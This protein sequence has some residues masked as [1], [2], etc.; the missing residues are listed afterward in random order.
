MELSISTERIVQYGYS[1]MAEVVTDAPPPGLDPLP[2][3]DSGNHALSEAMQTGASAQNAVASTSGN[4]N[5]SRMAAPPGLG[6]D[7]LGENSEKNNDFGG[8]NI[9]NSKTSSGETGK[10][11][12]NSALTCYAK[13]LLGE[14]IISANN[15]DNGHNTKTNFRT[16]K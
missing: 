8:D 12:R 2:A 6:D 4:I 1:R 15:L 11:R 10:E 3:T 7:N 9:D 16:A 13:N 5:T 14:P